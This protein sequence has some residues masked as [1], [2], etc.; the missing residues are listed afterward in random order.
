MLA[1]S[2]LLT[3]SFAACNR[4]GDGL[5]FYGTVDIR[6]VTLGFRVAGRVADLAVDEGDRV[7][8]GEV[9]ARLDATPIELE[10]NAVSYTHLTLPTNREV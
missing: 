7:H 6:E 8:A 4:A 2:V 1:A 5:R 10:V 3:G 9:I